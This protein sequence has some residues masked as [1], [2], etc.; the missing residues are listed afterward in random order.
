MGRWMHGYIDGWVAGWM[1][2]QIGK[3]KKNNP[4]DCELPS[5]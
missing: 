2:R 1:E 5:G 3:V 4:F